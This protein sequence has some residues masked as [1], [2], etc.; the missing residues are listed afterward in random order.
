MKIIFRLLFLPAVLL[1]S[2]CGSSS[3][4]IEVG[5]TSLDREELNTWIIERGY[6]GEAP[7][8][9]DTEVVA[10]VVQQFIEFEA[11]VDLLVEHDVV[12]S[13]ADLEEAESQL[14]ANGFEPD[15]P[16]LERLTTWQAA[17]NL[18][19]QL[20]PGVESAYET[21]SHLAG[22]E[23]CTSHILV[24]SRSEANDLMGSLADGADF[25]DLAISFSQDPGSGSQGGN[26]GC[27]ATGVFVPEFER[28]V[29]G[30]LQQLDV[31][32]GETLVGPVQSQFGFH[33]IRIDEIKV[34]TPPAFLDA[35]Q[36]ALQQLV[37]FAT[38]TREVSLDSRYGS[39]DAVIGKVEP[40]SGPIDN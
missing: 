21:Y 40:P 16:V 31:V 35:G 23:L 34:I 6:N 33:I 29:L 4:A 32:P 14:V 25:S 2:S 18:A 24:S 12:P 5:Q 19:N 9:L 36:K 10:G 38:M 27:V 7:A 11:L 20:G 17:L 37:E 13:Q 26:L 30:A 3:S 1:L 22:H 15:S 39:W 28:A 8:T